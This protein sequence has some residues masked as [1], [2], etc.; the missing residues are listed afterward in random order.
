MII[1]SKSPYQMDESTLV[2]GTATTYIGHSLIDRAHDL[3]LRHRGYTSLNCCELMCD[4]ISIDTTG[5]SLVVRI[6]APRRPPKVRN[7]FKWEGFFFFNLRLY[8]P[9]SANNHFVHFVSY[10]LSPCHRKPPGRWFC[11]GGDSYEILVV[12]CFTAQIVLPI[13]G[14][15]GNFLDIEN[16]QSSFSWGES[17]YLGLPN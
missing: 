16:G 4:I 1:T 15:V 10:I 7:Y 14:S 5:H 8:H 9:V 13:A 6:L 3:H 12:G 2:G 17:F 11:A